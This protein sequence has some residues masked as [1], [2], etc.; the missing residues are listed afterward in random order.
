MCI[1]PSQS[2]NLEMH[3]SRSKRGYLEGSHGRESSPNLRPDFV[4]LRSE[5]A[6]RWLAI[7]YQSHDT[8]TA[9]I[10]PYILRPAMLDYQRSTMAGDERGQPTQKHTKWQERRKEIEEINRLL[11]ESA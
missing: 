8:Y 2:Q 6:H 7:L 9:W 5:F 1:H 11:I 4:Q 3:R 10:K